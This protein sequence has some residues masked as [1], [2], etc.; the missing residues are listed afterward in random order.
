M[1]SSASEPAAAGGGARSRPLIG[2]TTYRERAQ[3]LVW[4]T[5]FALLHQ[6]YVDGVARAG[7]VPV[8]LPPQEH[9]A[10]EVVEALDGLVLTGGSPASPDELV[11]RTERGLLLTCLWY[12]REVDP[13]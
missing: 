8:L 5:E 10:R 6:V 13:V 9:G 7:G 12:I 2:L 1:A 4:D 11:G 3:T